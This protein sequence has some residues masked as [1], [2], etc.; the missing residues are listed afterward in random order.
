[1]QT[2][3]QTSFISPA[4]T[5]RWR[6]TTALASVNAAITLSWIIYRAHLAG[7]L[8]QAGFP[9][10]FAPLLLLVESVL[11]IAV[12]PWAGSTSDRTLRQLGGRFYVITIG[13]AVTAL[14]F[15]LLPGIVQLLPQNSAANWWFPGLLIIWAV[16]ISMFRSPALSLLGDY[17]SP[18]QLPLA[19]SLITCA[20]ALAGAATPLAN[21]WI[22]S[23][24]ITATFIAAAVSLIATVGW[25]K[26]AQPGDGVAPA[27]STHQD[28]PDAPL[29]L[30]SC[31]RIFGLGLA[32]SLAFRLTVE[33]FPK[34]LKASGMQPPLFMGVLF[35][36]L[37]IGAL[38]SGQVAARWG[39]SRAFT[40]GLGLTAALLLLMTLTQ[41][42]LTAF[43]IALAFG[44]S[45]S[46]VSNGTLPFALSFIPLRH[47]GLSIG[48]FFSGAAAAASLYSG[49][50]NPSGILSPA[51]STGLAIAA[52]LLAGVCILGQAGSPRQ[53]LSE[54]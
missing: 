49:V 31:L 48:L 14:L 52:L 8:T 28:L 30:M 41:Q 17:A 4:P 43:L 7:L 39:N 36:S 47:A 19:A 5:V 46:L 25:L 20:G 3:S 9:A 6:P 21:N 40:V 37:A 12:E 44:A 23:L 38:L 32:V 33:F 54:N 45:F 1:M 18:R 2:P 35:I 16:A 10:A 24:G 22:L 27:S 53:N 13:T 29:R 26:S 34:V 11:A 50:L 15:L 51:V 42:P